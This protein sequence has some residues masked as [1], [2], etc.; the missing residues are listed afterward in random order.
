MFHDDDDPGRPGDEPGGEVR[1]LLA[2]TRADPEWRELT[3]DH[4][5]ARLGGWV[6][7]GDPER[8]HCVNHHRG[9]EVGL[10]AGELH[11]FFVCEAP[12]PSM[13]RLRW[14]R[15]LRAS[16]ALEH[17]ERAQARSGL[18]AEP[19]EGEPEAVDWRQEPARARAEGDEDV[20]AAARLH[21]A[22]LG[23]LPGPWTLTR[24]VRCTATGGLWA[25]GIDEEGD[26]VAGAHDVEAR[27]SG[28]EPSFLWVPRPGRAALELF[29]AA[30]IE[31]DGL[32]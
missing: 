3:V 22:L 18:E 17:V 30:G 25:F 14:L 7:G 8:L 20:G 10:P 15:R 6:I 19:P 28:Q 4:A 27:R 9:E 1:V 11:A 16:T 21:E 23:T 29:L 2:L 13:K 5:D 31:L 32:R 24:V 12:P 26:L